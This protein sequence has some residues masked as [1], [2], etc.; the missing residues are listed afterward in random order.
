MFFMLTTYQS[1]IH[2]IGFHK[3][4]NVL[5]KSTLLCSPVG[6]FLFFIFCSSTK[7]TFNKSPGPLFS[8]ISHHIL[9]TINFKP[10]SAE[11]ISHLNQLEKNSFCVTDPCIISR[12]M[13]TLA[14]R[15]SVTQDTGFCFQLHETAGDPVH[16]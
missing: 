1:L 8:N 2:L 12:K 14:E 11:V 9:I 7:K 3:S 5:F 6:F 15:S 10:C 16:S 4:F 13:I